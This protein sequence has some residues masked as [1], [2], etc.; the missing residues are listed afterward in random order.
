M[1]TNQEVREGKRRRASLNAQAVV[2]EVSAL[3]RLFQRL[4]EETKKEF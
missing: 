4:H 3:G 2:S 1:D